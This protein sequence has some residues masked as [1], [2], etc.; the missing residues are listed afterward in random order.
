MAQL[1]KTSH[2]GKWEWDMTQGIDA[3]IKRTEAMLNE[4]MDRSA[5][6]DPSGDLSGAVV[7]FQVADNY[8]YYV[9][10]KDKPLT[11]QLIPF[12]DAYQISDAHMRGLRREDV[13]QQL[14]QDKYW[15]DRKVK[16]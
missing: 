4:L 6:V 14:R 16:A 12:C 11:L 13:V 10:I 2:P 8:A 7:K 9:V 1:A 5:Q 3:E 15:R